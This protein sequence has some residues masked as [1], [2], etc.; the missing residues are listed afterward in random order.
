[1]KVRYIGFFPP[2]YGGVTVKNQ[3]LY[4]L[5]SNN[6]KIARF[7]KPKW[8]HSSIYKILNLFLALFPGQTLVIGVSSRGGTGKRLTKLLYMLN[9]ATMRRSIYFMMGGVETHNVAASEE[10]IKWMSNYKYVYVETPG[11]LEEMKACGI[12]NSGLYPNCRRRPNIDL[13]VTDNGEAPLRCVYFAQISKEKGMD[14]V[15]EAASELQDVSF[16]LY[17]NVVP[18]YNEEFYNKIQN[19][20]NVHYLGIYRDQGNRLYQMLNTYDIMLFPTRWKTEGV[21]G[22]LVDAKISGIAAIVSPESH[23]A[24]LVLDGI[25]GVVMP[26]NTTSCL[27]EAVNILQADKVQLHTLK[28]GSKN[29]AER[30]YIENYADEILSLLSK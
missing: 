14:I 13:E 17:G 10:Y 4:E 9:R 5:I 26:E 18:E 27:I 23:N 12:T 25:E 3:L 2:P 7:V 21:P 28:I 16:D 30:F 22:T 29:S 6:K 24:E 20:S 11:M 19:L 15:L 8:L 1:M